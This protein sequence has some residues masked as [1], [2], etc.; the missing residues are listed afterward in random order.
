MVKQE[1][2]RTAVRA[3]WTQPSQ[4]E[5][6]WEPSRSGGAPQEATSERLR[7]PHT[8]LMK[9]GGPSVTAAKGRDHKGQRRGHA[10]IER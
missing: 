4:A 9:C 1:T 2:A 10:G 7:L 5:R 3:V 8:S 6:P